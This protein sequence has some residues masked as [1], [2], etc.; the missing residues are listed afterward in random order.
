MRYWPQLLDS[1]TYINPRLWQ[2][3]WELRLLSGSLQLT[4]QAVAGLLSDSLQCI[5]P[6]LIHQHHQHSRVWGPCLCT[7]TCAVLVKLSLLKPSDRKICLKLQLD[8][9]STEAC[10]HWNWSTTFGKPDSKENWN[11]LIM[12]LTYFVTVHSCKIGPPYSFSLS[13]LLEK[14]KKKGQRKSLRMAINH[15]IHEITLRPSS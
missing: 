14:K 11:S 1:K 12:W 15:V 4:A 3:H 5:L 13:A 7:R 6:S 8:F 10:F 9:T 2:T